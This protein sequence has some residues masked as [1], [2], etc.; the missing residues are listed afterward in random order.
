MYAA[1][2]RAGFAPLL[3]T[4]IVTRLKPLSIASCP[5]VNLPEEKKG[6]WGERF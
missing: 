1:R 3:R 2:V 4:E 6:R 5:F